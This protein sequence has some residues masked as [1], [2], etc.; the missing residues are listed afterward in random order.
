LYPADFKLSTP[1]LSL[2]SAEREG[3]R[4]GG[5]EEGRKE[6]KKEER[7]ERRKKGLKE[8]SCIFG[9]MRMKEILGP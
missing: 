9:V 8:G 7:K 1:C 6:G 5:T 4:E 2:P 3:G